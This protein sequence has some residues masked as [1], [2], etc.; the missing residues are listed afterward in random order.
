MLLKRLFLAFFGLSAGSVIA[1]G[2]FAFL[3]IIGVFPRLIGKTNTKSHILL[4]E[5]VIILGGTAGNVVYLFKLPVPLSRL[6][7]ADFGAVGFGSVSS[8]LASFGSAGSGLAS[9]GST[10]SGLVSFGSTG[11]GT[12]VLG[13]SV[14]GL[15]VFG[16][17]VF[18]LAV[19]VFVGCLIMSLAETLKTLPVISRRIHLTVGLQWLILGIALGKCFGALLYFSRKMGL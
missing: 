15:A 2:V 6:T 4:Y 16:L 13:L 1:A 19:G 14:S 8:G 18:G 17:A 9:F 11:S 7:P 3:A 12:A 10:G 5:T